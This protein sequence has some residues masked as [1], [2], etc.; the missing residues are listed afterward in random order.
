M[1]TQFETHSGQRRTFI[2]QGALGAAGLLTA[3]AGAWGAIAGANERVRVAVIGIK[4]RGIPLIRS[5]SSIP[6]VQ[7]T[8]VSDV[9][10]VQLEKGMATA[11]KDLGYRPQ[12]E[13]DMRKIVERD[14]VDAVFVATPDHLH[15]YQTLISLQNGKH[16]YVEKP[17]SHNLAEDALLL[18]A[19]ERYPE[20]CIQMGTQQ[21]SSPE[22]REVIQAIHEGVI[23][24]PYK[25]VAFYANSRGAVPVPVEMAPPATLDWELWQG[26]APRRPF[27]DILADYNW[28]WRWHWGTAES[29]NNGTHEMDVARWALQV[30]Y[31]E[32][33]RATGGKFHFVNDGWEMYDTMEVNLHYTGNRVIQWNGNSRN[34]YTTFG[35]GRGTV[36]YGTEG[37]VYVDRDGYRIYNRSGELARESKG[38]AEGGIALGGGGGMTTR[39]VRNF[40]EAIRSG[41][42]LHAPISVGAVSTSM[43][44]YVNVA[45]RVEGGIIKVDPSTGR[46]ADPALMKRYWGRDYERGWEPTL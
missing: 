38:E 25:A 15:A 44:H 18:K 34:G 29:A 10:S 12:T 43:T 45:S 33:V 1:K 14:D 22:T 42:T 8:W 23:G 41:E 7:V 32:E 28:H 40:I 39:H 20:L 17:C 27:M 19:Q 36:I 21:R 31:P 16:V 3:K 9:D 11:E 4:R 37:S 46:L 35:S 30:G 6:N 5:L 24:N 26:P 2:K 13:R